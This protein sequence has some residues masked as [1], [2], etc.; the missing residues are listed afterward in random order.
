MHLILFITIEK[1]W[2]KT[3]AILFIAVL[4]AGSV[5]AG[6]SGSASVSAG[7]NFETKDWGFFGN[8]TGVKLDVEL[9]SAVAEKAGEGKVYASIKASLAVDAVTTSWD[10]IKPDTYW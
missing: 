10:E 8:D 4:A 3:I 9:G 1:W 5:F 7:Y 2:K 6:F